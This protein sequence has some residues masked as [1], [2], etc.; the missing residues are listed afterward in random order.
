VC[1]CPCYTTYVQAYI[2][3]TQTVATSFVE[4]GRTAGCALTVQLHSRPSSYG[5]YEQNK[6]KP[7]E[8]KKNFF[9]FVFIVVVIVVII[10]FLSTGPCLPIGD[11]H[12][13]NFVWLYGVV[14]EVGFILT[15]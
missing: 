11:S 10:S 7:K 15:T 13:I 14:G 2:Q 3:P 4:N 6:I 8:K 5:S 12:K 9:L 1:P